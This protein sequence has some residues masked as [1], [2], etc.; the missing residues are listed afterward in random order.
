MRG[1]QSHAEWRDFFK[2][3]RFISNPAYVAGLANAIQQ[4][5]FFCPFLQRH[6]APSDFQVEGLNHREGIQYGGL[7]SRMRA[8]WMQLLLATEGR[9]PQDLRIYAPEAVTPLALML[10]G[11][12]ARFVGSEFSEDEV[13]IENLFPIRFESLLQLS[14]T[15]SV[16]DVVIVNDVFEHVP[17]INLC[18][19]E[20]ARVTRP[21]GHLISTFPFTWK[22]GS[23]VKARLQPE[24]IEYL[25]E[26]EYH[27]NPVDPK[28]S[29]VFEIPGWNILDRA[30][31]AGWTHVEM[32]YHTSVS[33]GVLGSRVGGIV[34]LVAKR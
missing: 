17:D 14:F 24:G 11:R 21:G 25:T 27:E 16:F 2:A 10:R 22:P 26:P 19:S 32:V 9:Q 7:N 20:L 4:N 13:V 29:L 33:S 34:I 30:R 3:H 12:Y 5:G 1:F 6:V 23:T 18:L 15:D 31:D 8:V 28:G